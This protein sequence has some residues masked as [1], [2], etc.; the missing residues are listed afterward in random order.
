MKDL[1]E[2]GIKGRLP[3][4]IEGFL[5]NRKF[6]VRI[7]TTFSSVKNQG[8]GVPQGS[9]LS[10]TLF[11]IKMNN[12]TKDFPS[13]IDGWPHNILQIEIYPHNWMKIACRWA[14]VNGFK[15]SETKTKKCPFLS[16]KKL[17]NDPSL[18]LNDVEIP[19]VDDYKFLGI[20][21][22]KKLT[23]IPHLKYLKMKCN[24]HC[25]CCMWWPTKNEE[26]TKILYYYY[27]DHKLDEK[28]D[29]GSIIYRLAGKSYLKILDPIFH[30]GLRLV[31]GAFRTS[32]AESLYAEANEAPANIRSRHKLALQI[33]VMSNKSSTP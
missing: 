19:V 28:L 8:V 7:D 3:Q 1:H 23:F 16:K 4:F 13:G 26:L 10:V 33:K 12:I 29:Y 27:I 6:K 25:S 31:L 30:G 24:K 22:Y 17:H 15:F 14:T 11:N 9:I 32:P 2:L 5:S 18:K 20:I 21:F